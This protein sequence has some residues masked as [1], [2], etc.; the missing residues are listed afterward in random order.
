MVDQLQYIAR[1]ELVFGLHIHV[2]VA[3]PDLAVRVADG[4]AIHLA[5]LLALSASSPF[6]RGEPTGLVSSRRMVVASLPRS[7]PMPRFADYAEYAEVIGQLERTGCIADY[8]QIWWDV[9]PNPRLGS[10]EIRVC[11]AVTDADDVLAIAAYC[12]AAVK[13]LQE[14]CE[15][16][17]ALPTYHRV[18]TGENLWLAAR[19]GLQAPV[20]DLA[21]GRRNRVPL[22]Q[23][24]RRSLRE[25]EG[26]ARE[27]GSDR[28]LDGIGALLAGGNGADRQLRAFNT[29]RDLVEVAREIADG[30]EASVGSTA[31]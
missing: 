21:S 6:W 5:P 4:L 10:V 3:S 24:I 11:D 28:E 15:K 9:R 25:L 26:H 29:N 1:R 20:M 16:G 13:A 18:L 7:G 27:L 8:T 31:S 30:T 2:A 23:L 17:L 19:H 22:A 14:R 12:Q